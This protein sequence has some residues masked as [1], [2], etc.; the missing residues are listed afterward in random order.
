MSYHLQQQRGIYRSL[1]RK[2]HSTD[3]LTALADQKFL[4]QDVPLPTRSEE[5]FE[6]NRFLEEVFADLHL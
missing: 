4:D 1:L 6:L 3:T 2:M 5:D